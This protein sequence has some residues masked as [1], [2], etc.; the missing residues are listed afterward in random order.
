MGLALWALTAEGPCSIPGWGTKNPTS[1]V[2]QPKEKKKHTTKQARA[3]NQKKFKIQNKALH[4]LNYFIVNVEFI[5]Y[6]NV[7]K[8]VFTM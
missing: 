8:K 7:D 2:V 3:W 4:Y 5:I 1:R 6:E